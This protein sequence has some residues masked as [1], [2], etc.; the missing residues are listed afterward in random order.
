MS[1]IRLDTA[2]EITSFLRIL[3]EESVKDARD[4]IYSDPMQKK[5]VDGIKS[6]NKIFSD[7][8]EDEEDEEGEEIISGD[9]DVE[10]DPESVSV[11]S[12]EIDTSSSDADVESEDPLGDI[13]T[14][15]SGIAG[16]FNKL[17]GAPSFKR[18]DVKDNI[19][20]YLERLSTDEKKILVTFLKAFNSMAYG[21]KSG[22]EAQDPS[23]P[24]IS[25]N[26]SPGSSKTPDAEAGTEEGEDVFSDIGSISV[27]DVPD[28]ES[29]EYEEEEPIEDTAP[30]I[31]AGSATQASDARMTEI[32]K[33][34][35]A[36]MRA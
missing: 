8:Y 12:S 34:V 32:R 7:I 2:S 17:R 13:L 15:F 16:E 5:I 20:A 26:V 10:S 1:N 33:R 3:A 25:L 6:D 23:D 27:S 35:R 14:T 22:M 24:P 28:V 4:M 36:L 30:P 19:K 31:R 29:E 18:G 11:P 21:Q 9:V